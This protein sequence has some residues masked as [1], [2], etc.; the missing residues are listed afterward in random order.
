MQSNGVKTFYFE[1]SASIPNNPDLPVLLYEGAFKDNPEQSERVFNEHNWRNS[2]QGGVF[3][4]HHFHSNTHEVLGVVSG[5]AEL[6]LGG[7]SGKKVE[8]HPGDVVVLPAGTGHK[9]LTASEDFKVAGAYP[10]GKDH[11]LK[12]GENGERNLLFSEI[13]EVGIPS[14]DP[15]YGEDGPLLAHWKIEE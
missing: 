12:T 13:K 14:Q 1:E 5:T 6:I 2:W 11:N 15:V 10:A 9:R 8:V 7:E 3:D 4:Y